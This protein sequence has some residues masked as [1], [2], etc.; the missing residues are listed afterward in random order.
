MLTVALALGACRKKDSS[1]GLGS[2]YSPPLKDLIMAHS[3]IVSDVLRNDTSIWTTVMDCEKD[4]IYTFKNNDI[5]TMDE[6]HAK[7][8]SSN[9]QSTDEVWKLLDDSHKMIFY[10]DTVEIL[11]ATPNLRFR[12]TDGTDK[13]VIN[14]VSKP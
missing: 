5:M 12:R 6:G 10:S 8:N 4:N 14:M 1:P 3:W 2:N 13:Y 11:V 7:C 9:P